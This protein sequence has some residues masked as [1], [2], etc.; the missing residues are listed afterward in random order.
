MK[1]KIAF[2]VTSLNGGGLEN[3]LL[4]FLQYYSDKI[5]A[6]VFC[7]SGKGGD[8]ET[9]YLKLGTKLIFLPMGYFSPI[10]YYKFGEQ[11]KSLNISSVCDFTGNFSALPLLTARLFGIRKRVAFYRG[12]TNHFDATLGRLAYNYCAN[13]LVR[14][15]ATD[16][17]SNSKAALDFFHKNWKGNKFEVIA[18]GVN[19]HSFLS[20]S[21]NLR[22][23]LGIK[24]GDFVVGHVGRFNEAKNHKTIIA[25]AKQI[26]KLF[27]VAKFVLCGAGVPEH[28]SPWLADELRDN[29]ILLDY[30][31]D[32]IKVLNSCD[33]FF[34]PSVTEGQPNALIEAMV[35]ALPI[36]ASNI[37]PIKECVPQELVKELVSPLDVEGFVIKISEQINGSAY[38]FENL[39]EWAVNSYDAEKCFSKFY[40][41][42]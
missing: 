30:R 40:D 35:T 24:D 14:Y 20:T 5:D 29:I 37:D 12:A 2:V 26:V 27:P 36:V 16:I 34:F 28:I 21:K 33:L 18:N 31:P 23:E 25:V 13:I 19:A 11:L 1:I 15:S 39:K 8:L 10:S 41:R 17:L 6:I 22:S 7:K 9:E 42:L 38:R 4:R 3:Y 32:V